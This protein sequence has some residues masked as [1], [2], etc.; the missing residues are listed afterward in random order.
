[1]QLQPQWKLRIYAVIAAVLAVFMGYEIASGAMLWPAVCAAAV[2][3]VSLMWLQPLPPATVALG[4]AL[5][6]YIVGNRGFAQL[7]LAGN[8]PILPAEVVLLIGGVTL[9]VRSA[10]DRTLPVR[11]DALNLLVLFW[12]LAS[13]VRLYADVRTHGAM[14]LRDYAMVY[15]AAFF[16]IGQHAAATEPGRRFLRQCLLLG[17]VGLVFLYPLFVQFTDLFLGSLTFRGAPLI[18]YKGDLVGTY[19]AVG[20]VLLYAQAHR[21]Q[22]RWAIGLSLVLAGAAIAT[23]NRASMLGLFVATGL[24]AAAGRWRFAALQAS[25]GVAA[26]I[27]LLFVAY[28]RNE[29]WQSTPIYSVYE[30]VVSLADPLGRRTYTATETFN[31]G[32]NN[33]FRAVW[34]RLVYDEAMSTS[35]VLGL[36]YG[37]D[38]ADRFVR[39]YY[40]DLDE[41]TTR[42]PHNFALT[43]FARTG[44][45]GLAP[46]L[47][48]A[49]LLL[50]RAVRAARLDVSNG[51][52]WCGAATI[53]TSSLFGVVLEGPMGAI[54]FWTLLGAANAEYA[55]V[56]QTR[57]EE[58]EALPPAD[59][60]EEV[61]AIT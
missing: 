4:L 50:W 36:G 25:A 21:S 22:S 31:K 56:Q 5:F 44:V 19:L 51:A 18:Y 40:P 6:G 35:P 27:A 60:P 15:Y 20:A 30:R 55:A 33:V 2:L 29:S 24:L 59:V 16:F 37:H 1:M 32:D 46:F 14:A 9:V 57:R 3:I 28:V 38:L 34:W 61:A 23:N 53:L 39:E 48:I 17:C 41:F 26:A 12:I 7:S 49:G 43:V 52:M 42:S 11:R 47:A 10:L 58:A 54:V 8:L 13:S 45:I